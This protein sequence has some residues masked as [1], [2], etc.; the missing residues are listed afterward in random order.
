MRLVLDV[1]R[2]VFGQPAH[3]GEQQLRAAA[4]DLRAACDVGVCAFRLAVVEREDVVF[5]RFK[6]EQS[7]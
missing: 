3:A 7:L 4:H 2:R 1:D 6:I 5:R